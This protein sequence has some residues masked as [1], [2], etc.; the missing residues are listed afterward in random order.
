MK[1]TLAKYKLSRL[2]NDIPRYDHLKLKSFLKQPTW[3]FHWKSDATI[4]RDT[5]TP[6]VM[7]YFNNLCLSKKPFKAQYLISTLDTKILPRNSLSNVLRFWITPPRS[8]TCTC[9]IETPNLVHHLIFECRL[10]RDPMSRY[11]TTLCQQLACLMKPD[12]MTN[13]FHTIAKSAGSLEE[14]NLIIGQF[15]IPPY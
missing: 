15:D 13:F 11:I 2:W 14:F 3:D 7:A 9:K 12:N 4:A 6:F 10:T 1:Y 8:R 5:R